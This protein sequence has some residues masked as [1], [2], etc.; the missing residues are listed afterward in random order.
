VLLIEQNAKAALEIA[1]YAYVLET[2]RITLSGTGTELLA[3]ESVKKAY[4]GE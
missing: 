2:G 4:L 1:D 3:S